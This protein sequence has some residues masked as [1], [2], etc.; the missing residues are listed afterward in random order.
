MKPHISHAFRCNFV[1]KP[2]VSVCPAAAPAKPVPAEQ[3][4][5]RVRG[6]LADSA[7]SDS[8]SSNS[9]R[10]TSSTSDS[11]QSGS[12]S[13]NSDQNNLVINFYGDERGGGK[14]GSLR[15]GQ[16]VDSNFGTHKYF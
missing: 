3:V 2:S 16:R 12:G 11:K 7:A 5:Q 10:Q 6:G 4:V 15:K 1:K 9:K 13:H 8:A 14:R